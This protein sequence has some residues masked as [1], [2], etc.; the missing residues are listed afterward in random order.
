[1]VRLTKHEVVINAPATEVYRQLTTVD[2][3]L[4]WIAV[5]AVSVPVPGGRLQWTHENGA[6][7]VGRFLELDPPHRLVIAYGW[8]DDLNGCATRVDNR[9]D[10]PHGAGRANHAEIGPQEP[11]PGRGR[12]PSTRLDLLPGTTARFVGR[13]IEFVVAFQA[14][15]GLRRRALR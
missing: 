2:G 6:T 3:L 13:R 10:R 15:A 8:K 1:M 14:S 12:R 7:M 11:S 9:R 5:D 4:R